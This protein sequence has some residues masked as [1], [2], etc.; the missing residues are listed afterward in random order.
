MKALI[1]F[2]T[3][4][5][6]TRKIVDFVAQ[7]MRSAGY[8]VQLFD[9]HDRLETLSFEGIG[10]VVL[11]A[12]VHERRHPAGFETF[13]ATNLDGLKARNTLLISVSLKAAFLESIDEAQDYLIEM[14]MRTRF[15]PDK[16]ILAAGAVRTKSYDYYESQIVKTVA[17]EGRK[18][19]LVNGVREFTNWDDLGADVA[20]FLT[21]EP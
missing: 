4:E 20:D 16:E 17:L 15:E 21:V 5:G 8:E 9:T 1:V 2:E 7:Q 13:I 18:V 19:A 14:K 11:A 10:K 12:P 3:V 6:Q